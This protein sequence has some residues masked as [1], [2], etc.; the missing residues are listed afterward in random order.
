MVAYI[1]RKGK[2]DKLEQY[3]VISFNDI[4]RYLIGNPKPIRRVVTNHV[5]K[6]CK[7]NIFETFATSTKEGEIYRG[8][9]WLNEKNDIRAREI[10]DAYVDSIKKKSQ[11]KLKGIES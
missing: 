5:I 1:F 10:V 8:C 6:K 9:F 3:D 7:K 11:T 4:G 2:Y